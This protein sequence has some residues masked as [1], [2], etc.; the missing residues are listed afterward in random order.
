M[1]SSDA[2]LLDAFE[3]DT[4]KRMDEHPGEEFIFPDLSPERY[5]QVIE[6]KGKK[7]S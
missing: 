1:L 6:R 2:D 4:A 7:P 5:Q 3:N